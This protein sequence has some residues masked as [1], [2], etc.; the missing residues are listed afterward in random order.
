MTLIFSSPVSIGFDEGTSSFTS[1]TG[2]NDQDEVIGA[3][4]IS[5]VTWQNG[6]LSNL[7]YLS[8]D[9]NAS[10]LGINDAGEI[11]GAS[12]SSVANNP[13]LWL[14]N[15]APTQIAA[16][17]SSARGFAIN[18]QGLIVGS[19]RSSTTDLDEAFS[20]QNGQVTTLAN[21][22]GGG[23]YN[24][25]Y[26]NSRALGV[27]DADQIVGYG[28]TTG[29]VY[30]A[31]LWQ[32][33]TVTD[34]GVLSGGTTSQASAI[35][36]GGTIVGYSDDAS[37]VGEAVTWQNG[38]IT[39]LP[40]LE[41]GGNTLAYGINNAGLIVG[42]SDVYTLASGWVEHAVLWQNGTI[43]DLNA[44]LPANSGWVLNY[45]DGISNNGE[46]AGMGTYE[47]VTTAF[48]M[49]VGN[50]GTPSMSV[51]AAA[52]AFQASPHSAALS[53][54]DTGANI[55][56]GIVSLQTIAAAGKLLSVQF[57]DSTA[58][59][60]TLTA[61][62]YA[63][64]ADIFDVAS[65]AY[66]VSIGGLTVASAQTEIT[67]PHV[68]AVGIT[69]ASYNVADNLDLLQGWAA[70]GELTGITFTDSDPTLYLT[71]QNLQNDGKALAAIQG[72]YSIGLTGLTASQAL[73]YSATPHLTSLTISDDAANLGN[74]A[75]AL[76]ALGVTLNL[77]VTDSAANISAN[78][79]ALM[80]MDSTLD[81][82]T[83]NFTDSGQPV[84]HITSE[85]ED[86]NTVG[87]AMMKNNVEI[88]VD[89]S[90]ANTN[91]VGLTHL[92][93]TIV[94]FPDP[95]ADY[96][97]VSA[98][99]LPIVGAFTVTD[100][101][102]GRTSSDYISEVTAL[103]FSDGTYIIANAPV[104]GQVNSGTVTE[105][106][107]AVLGREPDVPG[108]QFYEEN[109]GSSQMT[110]V[111]TYFLNSTEYTSNPA[112]D[113]AQSAAG[114]AQFIT[115]IYQNLLHRA[116]DAGSVPFYQNVIA[117]FTDGLTAGTT[118]YANAQMQGHALVL[119]YFSASQEF[120]SDVQVT[121][122][123]PANAQHWLYLI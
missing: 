83:W 5:A 94:S 13:V 99:G 31:T 7:S 114:D 57:T 22:P 20:E 40:H 9:T 42:R 48:L 117:Q 75:S 72:V 15:G 71:V 27:N 93:P 38:A 33:G 87:L 78:F 8:G 16:L 123:H 28:L 62:Q 90:E 34:L 3:G 35:N 58:P 86:F 79:S 110:T 64:D 95:A 47:G 96:S 113:Y 26:L 97:V 52:G 102:T 46:I 6:Q 84:L 60:F 105:L 65:G 21:L 116:P 39:E 17:G 68:T 25:S 44:M 49:A 50:S 74:A 45:A 66:N 12:N 61:S 4:M 56:A 82:I 2:I 73:L 14:S 77:T 63:S 85:Q 103:Q 67:Q 30:H 107:A 53:V 23:T 89:A 43:T 121:A 106:Y 59:T 115:D 76:E 1:V 119:V 37:G 101:G 69:D 100:T 120:L 80:G 104:Q 11:V 24:A 51:A 18:D 29:N 118:A 36:A 109:T 111:A 41:T 122:Q 88:V 81:P 108:L 92:H 55:E 112:H 91:V 19:A 10:A 32:N 98:H 70:S 54:A